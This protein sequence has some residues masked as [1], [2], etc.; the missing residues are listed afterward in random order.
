MAT[1]QWYRLIHANWTF[2]GMEQSFGLSERKFPIM[3]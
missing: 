2:K 1:Y 3:L